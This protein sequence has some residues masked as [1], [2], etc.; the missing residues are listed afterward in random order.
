MDTDKS[1]IRFIKSGKVADYLNYVN[2]C[3]ENEISDGITNTVYN[4]GLGNKG[5]E[6]GGE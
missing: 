6:R 2:S 4:R 1:W 5:N 3:K